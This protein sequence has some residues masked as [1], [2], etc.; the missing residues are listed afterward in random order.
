V[1]ELTTTSDLIELVVSSASSITTHCHASYVDLQ[2]SP[3]S[4][5]TP[6]APG[7]QNTIITGSSGTT[8][9]VSAPGTTGYSRALKY[10]SIYNTS[11][12]VS[13]TITVEHTDG[14]NVVTLQGVV[15]QPL[16]TLTY[17]DVSGWQLIDAN[18]G[19]IGFPIQGRWLKTSVL[20]ATTAT[21]FTTTAQTRSLRV[22]M[23]GGGGS[24]GG[25]TSLAS[26]AAGAPGG[27][28]GAYA[29][30]VGAV[31]PNTNYSYTCGAA[32]TGTSG[33]A[34]T[35]GNSTT[36]AAP[37]G[38]V[39]CP[40]GAGGAVGTAATTLTV[41]A[42]AAGGTI[43][44]GGTVN[45]T[46]NPGEPGMCL[47]VA[48]PIVCGGKGGSSPFGGGGAGIIAV[49]N[50]N[51]AGGYGAGGGGACTGAS[52]VRTGGTSTQGVVIIDEFS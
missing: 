51:A 52:T 34:G 12:T 20:T 7:R 42:G 27:G 32:V 2:G 5:S 36:F 6:V 50:G 18:G 30:W 31:T 33:A 28:A 21:N 25:C 11:S 10:L 4:A 43:A 37:T 45:C 29:E 38:T 8:T 41:Y 22:R 16:W 46:G 9:I 44:T 3:A 35:N 13:N 49:G 40:G 24:G 19:Q 39:T 26:A 48:T 17:S 14:T 15:L 1:I 23:V 47:I